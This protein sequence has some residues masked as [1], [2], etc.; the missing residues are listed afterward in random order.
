MRAGILKGGEWNGYRFALCLLT[1][2]IVTVHLSGG[3]ATTL[4]NAI[5]EPHADEGQPA[6]DETIS[7]RLTD[8]KD[9]DDIIYELGEG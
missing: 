8:K 2:D 5:L 9:G 3:T 1:P 7:Y 4:L 6:R